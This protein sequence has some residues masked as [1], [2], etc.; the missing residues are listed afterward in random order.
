[1]LHAPVIQVEMNPGTT[2]I[3]SLFVFFVT[4][5]VGAVLILTHVKHYHPPI[6]SF[7]MSRLETNV[8]GREKF[9]GNRENEVLDKLLQ[10]V[11]GHIKH[12]GMEVRRIIKLSLLVWA[13]LL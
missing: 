5:C 11:M 4:Y 1:M 6:P 3:Y 7:I 10:A 9:G 12:S 2:V 8:F 13:L